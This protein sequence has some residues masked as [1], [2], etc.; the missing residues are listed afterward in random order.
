M[1][2]DR[3]YSACG[4]VEAHTQKR[5]KIKEVEVLCRTFEQKLTAGKTDHTDKDT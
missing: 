3:M 5:K 2:R 4:K 1:P